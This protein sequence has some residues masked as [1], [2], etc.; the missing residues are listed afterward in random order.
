MTRV[1]RLEHVI[2][3]VACDVHTHVS[4]RTPLLA[5]HAQEPR[6]L[7]LVLHAKRLL[8]PQSVRVGS[9]CVDLDVQLAH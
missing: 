4:W 3:T 7:R 5:T 1:L 8:V 2:D 9:V 6:V